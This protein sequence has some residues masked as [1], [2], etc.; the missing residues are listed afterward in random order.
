MA[1]PT[2]VGGWLLILSRFLIVYQPI[3][4]AFAA[5][6]ALN[7]LSVRGAPLVAVIAIR[8]VV[9]GFSVAAGLALKNEQPSAVGLA[10]AAL[11]MSAA[12]DV[13][14]YSTSYFPTNLPPGDAPVYA[15]ASVLF[16]AAWIAYLLRSRRVRNTY[17]TES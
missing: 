7:S 13:A 14:V 3:N 11:V 2:G 9:V 10:K 4:L 16:H 15:A 5:A 12:S 8:V 6:A 1:Q 17:K